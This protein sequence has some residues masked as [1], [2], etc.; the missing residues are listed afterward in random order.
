M[1]LTLA[2]LLCGSSLMLGQEWIDG[3]SEPATDTT[4]A[5]PT[6]GVL[7]KI[8]VKDGQEVKVGDLLATLDEEQEKLEVERRSLVMEAAKKDYERTKQVFEN[9]KS[10]S[11]DELEQKEANFKVAEVEHRIAKASLARRQLV[12]GVAGVITDHFDLE[13]GELV[14]ANAPVIRLVNPKLCRFTCHVKGSANHGL[15]EG[16]AV[17]IKFTMEQGAVTFQGAVDFVSPTVDPA[18]GLQV[19]KA[20]FA[21]P[22]AKVAPGLIGKLQRKTP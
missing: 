2:I 16:G 19:I 22:E 9:G 1:R 12:A 14:Q 20:T 11:R 5:F 17:V 3:L 18:S 6:A 21:N 15:K 4:L 13:P 10:V 8:L 7:G